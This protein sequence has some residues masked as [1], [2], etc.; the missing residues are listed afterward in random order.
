[1]S[2]K[3]N[4]TE[5]MY[6]TP[7]FR[8]AEGKM[9][10][11][12]EL[13][14]LS[15]AGSTLDIVN[16]L[17]SKGND[18]IKSQG[19]E[20]DFDKVADLIFLDSF[21]LIDEASETPSA[22]DFFKYVYDCH[23]LKSAI[24]C[25]IRGSDPTPLM[26]ACSSVP[27][28]CAIEAYKNSG[29]DKYPKNMSAA[30]GKAIEAYAKTS[31]P[32]LIDVIL[33]KACFA[34]MLECAKDSGSDFLYEIVKTK[35]DIVNILICD[36]IMRLA[37][38][39]TKN[40]LL[41]ETFIPGGSLTLGFFAD[42]LEGDR[43]HFAEKLECTDYVKMASVLFDANA[44]AW[45]LE[46]AADNTYMDIALK[47]KRVAFGAPVAAGYIIAR[48][49][50]AKNVRILINGKNNNLSPATIRERLRASYE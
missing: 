28:E 20:C 45:K 27:F 42:M 23:N 37:N 39:Y 35:I 14:A 22:Y 29:S 7:R 47:A 21:A 26:Y 41:E 5:Y 33:D 9:L 30:I 4:K 32:Q 38:Q 49:L 43:R 19:G 25:G 50:E 46:C 15:E 34:D 8:F 2:K 17:A 36:R 3:I 12:D 6:S 24:K 1:M 13:Y 10:T 40:A 16:K 48:E 11:G 44:P 31:N 18:F